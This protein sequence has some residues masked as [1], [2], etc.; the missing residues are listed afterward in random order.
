M[1][2]KF[3]ASQ[4]VHVL[5]S[6]VAQPWLQLHDVLQDARAIFWGHLNVRRWLLCTGEESEDLLGGYA[7]SVSAQQPVHYICTIYIYNIYIWWIIP[8]IVGHSSLSGGCRSVRS[9][10]PKHGESPTG[11]CQATPWSSVPTSIAILAYG[12]VGSPE[13][14][15]GRTLDRAEGSDWL[16]KI[17]LQELL[18]L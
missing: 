16:M 18:G 14:N 12:V 11:S 3:R 7:Q 10:G 5:H 15:V 13:P 1:F 8:L 9:G 6:P 17:W 4:A 2:G